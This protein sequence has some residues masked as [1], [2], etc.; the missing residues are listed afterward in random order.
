[1]YLTLDKYDFYE[2]LQASTCR[3]TFSKHA[4]YAIFKHLVSVEEKTHCHR[5]FSAEEVCAMYTEESVYDFVL[6]T[7]NALCHPLENTEDWIPKYWIAL[8]NESE[9]VCH[10]VLESVHGWKKDGQAQR[11]IEFAVDALDPSEVSGRLAELFD[12]KYCFLQAVVNETGLGKRE[13]TI[14]HNYQG[15]R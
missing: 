7:A 2:A 9:E 4:A 12:L 5:A 11:V 1:M 13:V 10:S 8:Y 14:V 6:K 3:G 15:A